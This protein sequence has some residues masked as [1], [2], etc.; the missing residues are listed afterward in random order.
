MSFLY[1]KRNKQHRS[2]EHNQYIHERDGKW[3]VTQKGAGKVLSEHD[4][5]ED[6]EA[7]FRAMEMHKHA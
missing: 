2:Q 6:A 7:S 5:K 1:G 4:T 3:V